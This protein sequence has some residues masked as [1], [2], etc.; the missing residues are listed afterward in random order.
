MVQKWPGVTPRVKGDIKRLSDPRDVLERDLCCTS[1]TN[2]DATHPATN[3]PRRGLQG[4]R[5]RD[6]AL[7]RTPCPPPLR[8]ARARRGVNTARDARSIARVVHGDGDRTRVDDDRERWAIVDNRAGA[9]PSGR[10]RG[11]RGVTTTANARLTMD[12]RGRICRP[13]N[14]PPAPRSRATSARP[15]RR[16]PPPRCACAPSIAIERA[17]DARVERGD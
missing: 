1:A 8:C 13:S 4:A 7:T 6:P 2:R 3:R 10:R 15:R 14:S 16:A 5:A 9:T 12:A 17:C 11:R